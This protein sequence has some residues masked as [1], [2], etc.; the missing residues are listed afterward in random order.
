MGM[1]AAVMLLETMMMSKM[2]TKGRPTAPEP[3]GR[4]L[5]REPRTRRAAAIRRRQR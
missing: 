3:R 2:E 5:R 4:G 1:K